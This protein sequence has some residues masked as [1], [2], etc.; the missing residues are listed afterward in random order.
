MHI[1]AVLTSAKTHALHHLASGKGWR[2]LQRLLPDM[3]AELLRRDKL[4]RQLPGPS[5]YDH[6]CGG[7]LGAALLDARRPD[8]A[9]SI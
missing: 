4:A 6:R 7:P 8:H 5:V 1:Q 2:A 3:M 9:A